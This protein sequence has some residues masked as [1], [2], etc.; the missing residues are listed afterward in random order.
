MNI[1]KTY[2]E[3]KQISN[4]DLIQLG[5][6]DMS[7]EDEKRMLGFVKRS[8]FEQKNKMFQESKIN[9]EKLTLKDIEK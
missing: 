7:K 4:E 2:E 9:Y 5:W 6:T 8:M 3:F 1:P